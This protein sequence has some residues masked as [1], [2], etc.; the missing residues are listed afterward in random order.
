MD[1]N[2]CSEESPSIGFCRQ[3]FIG[4]VTWGKHVRLDCHTMSMRAKVN[5]L[6]FFLQSNDHQSRWLQNTTRWIQNRFLD[7]SMNGRH[8]VVLDTLSFY[9][10]VWLWHQHYFFSVSI[11]LA[12]QN[13][14]TWVCRMSMLMTSAIRTYASSMSFLRSLVLSGI[15]VWQSKVLKIS[16]MPNRWTRLLSKRVFIDCNYILLRAIHS[17]SES[18]HKKRDAK[19]P[20]VCSAISGNS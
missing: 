7:V 3:L 5:L 4:P 17:A 12:M 6:N 15:L 16:I 20:N 9:I 13:A 2:C 19:K 8:S 18:K 10:H 1:D 11:R 14:L